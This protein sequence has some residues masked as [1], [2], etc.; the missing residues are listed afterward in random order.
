MRSWEWMNGTGDRL[1]EPLDHA[2]ALTTIVRTAWTGVTAASLYV[3][4]TL[5]SLKDVDLFVPYRTFTLP[6]VGTGID[7][8]GF[9]V[10][11]PLLLL[12]AYFYF[13]LMLTRLFGCYHALLEQHEASKGTDT[14]H[15]L[16]SLVPPWFLTVLTDPESSDIEG[17]KRLDFHPVAF[18]LAWFFA[19]AFTPLTV[20]ALS[21]RYL[22][23]HDAF[24][25]FAHTLL[26]TIIVVAAALFWLKRCDFCPGERGAPD[27]KAPPIAAKQTAAAQAAVIATLF[28]TVCL[29]LF[30]QAFIASGFRPYH[31]LVFLSPN[32]QLYRAELSKRPAGWDEIRWIQLQDFYE[33]WEKCTKDEITLGSA[34]ERVNREIIL[35]RLANRDADCN[36]AILSR[37]PENSIQD[38]QSELALRLDISIG[39]QLGRIPAPGDKDDALNTNLVYCKNENEEVLVGKPRDLRHAFLMEAHLVGAN[40][41]CVDLSGADLRRARMD[42][43]SL[44]GANLTGADLKGAW[45]SGAKLNGALLKSAILSDLRTHSAAI[46]ESAIISGTSFE[47]ALIHQSDFSGGAS[48]VEVSFSN[49]RMNGSKFS[50]AN[51]TN[52]NFENASLV[53]AEF[54]SVEAQGV[55]F[56]TTNLRGAKISGTLEAADFSTAKLAGADLTWA[57]IK[58]SVIAS[59]ELSGTVLDYVD[60]DGSALRDLDMTALDH[61]PQDFSDQLAKAFGDG[62][63][64]LP[65]GIDRP[66]HWCKAVLTPVQF[67]GVWQGWRKA[68]G[69]SSL[70]VMNAHRWMYE[71]YSNGT[72][73]YP[74]IPLEAPLPLGCPAKAV[75]QNG[76]AGESRVEVS[77]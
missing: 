11:A 37:Q 51:L 31:P 58:D 38:L 8:R 10:F 61:V 56:S 40:L 44:W 46:F 29:Y 13:H 57:T 5:A 33:E 54:V 67:F 77:N 59:T 55:N 39:A 4:L 9:F 42:L 24:L 71:S 52:V 22:R 60:L 1:M 25:T 75:E 14:P 47:R 18:H 43:A 69:M 32:A 16:E 49:A 64:K 27:E 7:P 62:S 50:G 34:G 17:E 74:E 23:A 12:A 35:A 68:R 20:F 73:R 53:G 66:D 2:K 36:Q 70:S 41:D 21:F 45:L 30:S 15:I 72:R 6:V 63:V 26:T 65:E 19:Y 3:W 28:G 48:L 76:R